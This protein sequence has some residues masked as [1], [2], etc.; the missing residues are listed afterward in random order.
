V[1]KLSILFG[2]RRSAR[3]MSYITVPVYKEVDEAFVIVEEYDSCQLLKKF[4]FH[5]I[6]LSPHV[7]EVTG[8]HEYGF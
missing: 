2:I 1:T 5:P 6:F 4:Q 3:A 7:H 8:D